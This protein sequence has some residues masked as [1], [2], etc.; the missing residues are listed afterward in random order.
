[1][2][3]TYMNGE[4]LHIDS[5]LATVCCDTDDA[6][7]VPTLMWFV[8]IVNNRSEK[9]VAEKLSKM[10]VETYL[11]SHEDVHIWKSGKRAKVDKILIPAKIF[12]HCAEHERRELVK[13]PFIKRFMTNIAGTSVG[14]SNKPLAVVSDEEMF[15]L[16]FMLGAADSEVVFSERFVK[17]QKIEVVRGV[18]K[19][20]VGEVSLDAECGVN[21][22][23]VN[24]S[25]LGSAS[26]VINPKDIIRISGDDKR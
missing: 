19:G 2:I 7:G 4:N 15:K 23:Y 24:I 13:L 17:G 3:F 5:K 9:S 10:G 1:M 20:L 18:L 6:V 16:K 25:C 21:R 12:I 11:P 26:V 14:S 8:A 22:L